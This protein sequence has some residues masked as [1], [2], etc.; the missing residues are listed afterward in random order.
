MESSSSFGQG[1]DGVAK[2]R[3]PVARDCDGFKNHRDECL[4]RVKARE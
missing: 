3:P 2:L 4:R 1:F